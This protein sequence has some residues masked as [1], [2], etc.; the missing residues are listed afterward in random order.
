[1]LE[2]QVAGGVLQAHKVPR[3][4]VFGKWRGRARLPRAVDQYLGEVRG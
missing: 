2:F 4:D 3:E 1:M